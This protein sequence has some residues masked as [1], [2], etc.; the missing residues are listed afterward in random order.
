M[1][2]QRSSIA[3]LFSNIF[4]YDGLI[5]VLHDEWDS[6]HLARD[7]G[8]QRGR[9]AAAAARQRRCCA[10][11][12]PAR[13]ESRRGDR[14]RQRIDRR[15]R[16]PREG[17]RLPGCA[18]RGAPHRFGA[19]WRRR[20]RHGRCPVLYRCG[21]GD[22]PRDLQRDRGFVGDRPRGRGRDRCPHG[23]VVARHRHDLRPLHADGL[24]PAHGHGRGLLQTRGLSDDRRLRRAAFLCRGCPAFVGSAEG[25]SKTRT[26]ADAAAPV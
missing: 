14:G 5:G 22:P 10:R 16:G 7:S 17:A 9:A 12:L 18:G 21:F 11:S 19:Q 2:P 23:E 4:G 3:N 1:Y 26:A 13:R 20:G 24:A 15:H 6:P 8:L 25:W